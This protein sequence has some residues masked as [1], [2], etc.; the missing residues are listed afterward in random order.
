[1][2]RS[3]KRLRPKLR[4]TT[5]QSESLE[6]D[7]MFDWVEHDRSGAPKIL[8]HYTTWGGVEGILSSQRFWATAHDCTNDESELISAD[9][10][11]IE[12]ARDL[13]KDAV[14]TA[15]K[16][17]DAFLARYTSLHITQSITVCLAC[18]SIARDDEEQWRKYGDNGRGVCLGVRVLD[19]TPPDPPGALAEVVYSESSCRDAVARGFKPICSRLSEMTDSPPNRTLG[20]SALNRIAAFAS[21]TAKRP[22]WAHEKEF[23][24]LTLIPH[25]A[26][27]QLKERESAGKTIRYWPISVRTTGKRIALSE[28]T[29]GPNRSAEDARN[30]LRTLLAAN[31][32]AVGS[33]EYPEITFSS[34]TPWNI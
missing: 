12:V 22:K 34:I 2:P 17:L 6:L 30:Q 23:R 18:F 14:G 9:S 8:Y 10:I 16:V 13:R 4:S 19:E 1:M 7:R 25:D 32:Y 21:M 24:H 26:G 33:S 20:L 27:I 29:V 5:S 31:G 15:A 28:I 11:I 3:R